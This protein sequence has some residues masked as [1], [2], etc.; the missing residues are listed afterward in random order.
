MNSQLPHAKGRISVQAGERDSSQGGSSVT[1]TIEGQNST[2][3]TSLNNSEV[4]D[5][6]QCVT[7]TPSATQ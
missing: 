3:S 2:L 6:T 1:S 5:I 4:A 7:S